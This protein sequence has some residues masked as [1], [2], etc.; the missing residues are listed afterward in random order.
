MSFRSV[1]LIFFAAAFAGCSNA[2]FGPHAP[3][4]AG[5]GLS[6]AQPNALQSAKAKHHYVY[7]TL[8][9]SC[10]YPPI[11]FALIP[12]KMKSKHASYDCSKENGLGYTSGLGVDASGR[13]ISPRISMHQTPRVRGRTR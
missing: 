11:Q 8:F 5:P 2:A 10:K 1:A 12:M 6:F 7:W 9:A 3:L 4:A 13:L